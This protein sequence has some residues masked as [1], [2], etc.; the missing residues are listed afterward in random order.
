MF[1]VAM[2]CLSPSGMR[3]RLI[4]EQHGLWDFP[5]D[6]PPLLINELTCLKHFITVTESTQRPIIHHPPPTPGLL[7]SNY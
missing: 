6:S 2:G 1:P 4:K 7:L 3:Q 5:E